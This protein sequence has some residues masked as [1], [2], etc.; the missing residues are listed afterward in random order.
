MWVYV[1]YVCPSVPALSATWN[2]SLDQIMALRR[3]AEVSEVAD[4]RDFFE[5]LHCKPTNAHTF[6]KITVIINI[7]ATYFGAVRPEVCKSWRIKI[8]L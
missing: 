8:L 3:I 7:A 4:I 5:I 6:F 1:G 2:A